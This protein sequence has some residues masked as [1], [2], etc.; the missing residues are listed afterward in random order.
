MYVYIYRYNTILVNKVAGFHMADRGTELRVLLSPQTCL[1]NSSFCYI[2]LSSQISIMQ[3][4]CFH[5]QRN[6]SHSMYTFIA[7][8]Y[9][10]IADSCNK[11]KA[12]RDLEIK[13]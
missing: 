3:P 4:F 9:L 11:D 7:G 10:T 6:Y 12:Q 5:P 2:V 1:V 13:I 8:L